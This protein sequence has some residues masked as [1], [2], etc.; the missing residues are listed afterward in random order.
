[1][2]LW[3]LEQLGA[4]GAAY[5]IPMRLRL[6]GE[7]DREALARALD[8][9][10]ARHEALRTTFR[11]L[12]G[13]PAQRIAPA[14][15]SRF[16]LVDHDLAGHP[17]AEAELRRLAAGEAGAPFGLERGPLIRGR[18]VRL[19]ADDHVLLVTLH[20]IVSDGWSM[21]VLT[22]ELS[23]LYAAFRAGDA[24]PLPPLPIQYADYAAWQ[25]RW[26]DGEVL[27]RQ[28]DYWRDTLAGAPDLLELPTDHPRPA[29]QDF[30][31]A[32]ARLQLEEELAGAL[33]ALS[34]RRGTTLFVTLLAGWAATLGRLSGQTDV[35]V[36]APTANRGRGEIERLIGFFVNTLA[37]R[38]DL[39]GSPTV[40]ELLGRVKA[41]V[42]EAQQ[43]QDI[44]F[45]QVVELAQPE[46]SLAHSP[47][48][49]VMFAVQNAPR[50]RL[51]LPG[52]ELASLPTASQETAKFDLALAFS[53]TG[54]RI[55]GSLVYATSLFEPATVAR[56]LGYLRRLLE[57]MA[58]DEG[59]R[60][61]ELDLLPD[62][63]RRQLLEEWNRT[64]A[65]PADGACVHE[66][67]EA[68]A[69]RT[70]DAVALELGDRALTYGELSARAN[71]LAHRLRAG[72]VGPDVPVAIYAEPSLE[73][74]VGVLGVLK[75]GG[76]Y[77]PLDPRYPEDRLRY[78]LADSAPAV[79]LTQER[80]AERFAGLDV[81]VV[82]LD[83]EASSPAELPDTAPDRGG[84]APD[85]LAYVIYTS[86]STGRPKGVRVTHRGL[87]A[88]LLAAAEAYGF[89]A[90][91]R[92]PSLASFAF[93]I[94]LF[95]SLL[96][97]LRG[98][99]VR[100][101]PRERVVDVAALVEEAA[102]ATL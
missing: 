59:Q 32:L 26:V 15:E 78:M 71:R 92:M 64:G 75:A 89:R 7:L 27:R 53:E 20:H 2:R 37:L 18:L 58:A 91:D 19:A 29:R 44:P 4:L 12:D 5:H 11:T 51:E 46:R 66:L 23:T 8:R 49:Q 76:A 72:G 13:E 45:E 36:G 79:L 63:E 55:D 24:D 97:L 67:F 25:R 3:F 30:A 81:P 42:L 61:E 41:R 95:E 60:V 34:R 33:K 96:P 14:E 99:T 74:V 73:M 21:G 88:T 85:H 86:G 93:D 39:A 65:A 62:A 47:V 77:V 48:F 17:G 9:I 100:I 54:R 6:R 38:V 80:S 22:Q 70:P 94:W 56:H 83:G 57:A 68:Q 69:G 84:P 43:H 31:G 82:T 98:G 52:L 10:V 101:V 102:E 1:Q 28:A 16:H 87:A 50:D 35:V 40:A 90:G